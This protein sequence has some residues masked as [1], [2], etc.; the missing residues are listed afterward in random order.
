MF[1]VIETG[2][3]QYKVQY[4]DVIYVEK[5]AANEDETVQFPVIALSD[6]NG[7]KIGTPYVEGA[8]VTGKVLKNGKAKKV[9]IFTYKAKKSEKRKM[10]H[11]QPYTKIQIEAVQG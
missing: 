1:A 7:T 6:E 4:G 5:L 9:T 11:R 8:T 2:G 3:K 10:G